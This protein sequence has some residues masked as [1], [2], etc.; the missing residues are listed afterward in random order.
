MSD[1]FCGIHLLKFFYRVI[2]IC[3][4]CDID[5]PGIYI[6]HLFLKRLTFKGKGFKS[7]TQPLVLVVL[8]TGIVFS[9]W[10]ALL[11]YHQRQWQVM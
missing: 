2:P 1:Y 6:K 3:I 9:R 7:K 5:H 4:V 10:G 11:F 8:V